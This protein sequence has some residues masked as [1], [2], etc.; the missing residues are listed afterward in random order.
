M[1]TLYRD[2]DGNWQPVPDMTQT[3]ADRWLEAKRKATAERA[4]RRLIAPQLDLTL[5]LFA[6]FPSEMPLLTR[7][8]I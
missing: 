6:D 3:Q 2:L 8:S 7:R 5:D 4:N 1:K